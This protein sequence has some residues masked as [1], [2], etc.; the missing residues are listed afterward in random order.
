MGFQFCLSE[1]AAGIVLAEKLS[2]SPWVT[3]EAQVEIAHSW[4]C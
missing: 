2:S 1:A 3:R 4:S